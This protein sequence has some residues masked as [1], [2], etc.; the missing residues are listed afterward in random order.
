M[1]GLRDRLEEEVIELDEF[2]GSDTES[3]N[4]GES[5]AHDDTTE[6]SS[7]SSN[8]DPTVALQQLEDVA[9]F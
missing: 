7:E 5:V 9:V 6:T 1:R 3:A 8:S 4:S 2:V